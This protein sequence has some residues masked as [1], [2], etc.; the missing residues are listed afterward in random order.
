LSG[1]ALLINNFPEQGFNED[2][3]AWLL[4]SA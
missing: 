2:L 1:A 4:R 3:Y